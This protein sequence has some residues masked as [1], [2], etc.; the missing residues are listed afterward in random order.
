MAAEGTQERTFPDLI[1]HTAIYGSGFVATALVGFVL[2]PVYTHYLTPDAY[3]LLALMLVFY[4]LAKQVYDLGLT[5]SIARFFFDESEGPGLRRMTSTGILFMVAY[6]GLLT[7]LMAVFD[8]QISGVL[9]GT[10]RHGDLVRV[11]AVT[12]YAEALAIVPLTLIR[13]QERSVAFVSLTVAR[14][15]ASLVLSVVFVVVL[16][17]GVEGALWGNAVPAVGV[18]VLL[19]P[20]Y[21]RAVGGK[22]SYHLLRQMLAF[23]LPF[24]PVLLSGW[25]MDT[26][27]RWLIEIFRTRA[28]VGYYSLANRIGQI[29]GIAVAAF[30][31]GWAPLRYRIY[32]QAGAPGVYRRV[33]NYYAVAVSI[34]SV[35]IA[36]FGPAIVEVLAPPSYA[37]AA[38]VIPLLM[39]GCALQGLYFLMVTG[40]GV[41][42]K[43]TPMAW[44]SMTGAAANFGLNLFVIRHWGIKGAAATTAFAYLI[45][46]VGSWHYSQRVYP[47]P[48]DWIKF[49]RVLVVATIVVV[50]HSL[51]SPSD[52]LT[53]VA[54]AT[55]AWIT[56]VVLLVATR[57]I[58]PDELAAARR[59]VNALAT[60][61]RR[62]AA[63]PEVST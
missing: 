22:P 42:K 21:R 36:V 61:I 53:E 38:G 28:E 18:L 45:M 13:M 34:G 9:T 58:S 62:S 25:L 40:M 44:V 11:V 56:F 59:L 5:N 2:V 32:S 54:W 10:S 6:G 16:D 57:T 14:V 4:G 20:E 46:V 52:L 35:A 29:M 48:Y 49:A 31:M 17:M 63:E 43:T 50:A 1:R 26:S 24:F 55:A 60:R 8:S 51:V 27:D 3:G 33:A 12:L 15:V 47:I 41:T 7:A 39:L 19:T 23:G 37:P 30:M